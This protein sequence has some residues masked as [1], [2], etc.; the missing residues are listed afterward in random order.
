MVLYCP[1][2][3]PFPAV[4]RSIKHFNSIDI[5]MMVF[6]RLVVRCVGGTLYFVLFSLVTPL[7]QVAVVSQCSGAGPVWL[8]RQARQTGPVTWM[9][10]PKPSARIFRFSLWRKTRA[11]AGHDD[12]STSGVVALECRVRHVR[13]NG[14]HRPLPYCPHELLPIVG[15]SA[16]LWMGFVFITRPSRYTDP[17]CWYGL[18]ACRVRDLNLKNII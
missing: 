13:Q 14:Y 1:R 8:V 3:R 2:P 5:N 4:Q 16:V 18:C 17:G 11:C 6:V 12:F 15:S 9:L 10:C 7:V